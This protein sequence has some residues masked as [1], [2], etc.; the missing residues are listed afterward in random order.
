MRK[1]AAA[2]VFP[3]STRYLKKTL[4]LLILPETQ[5]RV[6]KSTDVGP[7]DSTRPPDRMSTMLNLIRY[8]R[9]VEFQTNTICSS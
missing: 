3:R 2:T 5:R 6:L 7:C 4:K 1:F 9:S 8:S